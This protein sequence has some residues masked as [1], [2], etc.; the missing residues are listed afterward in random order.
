M[1]TSPAL[2]STSRCDTSY[3]CPLGTRIIAFFKARLFS[4]R[5]GVTK[6]YVDSAEPSRVPAQNDL[7]RA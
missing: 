6:G 3:L 4:V 5:F 2:L 7:R 1:P